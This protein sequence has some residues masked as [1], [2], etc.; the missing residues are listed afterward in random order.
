MKKFWAV[1]IVVSV[2][3]I[4]APVSAQSAE[5]RPAGFGAGLGFGSFVTGVS[6]KKHDGD[7]ALQGVIGCGWRWGYGRRGHRTR[8]S[9]CR[10]M[11]VSGDL[12]LSMPVI[13]DEGSVILAWNVGGGASVGV[14]DHYYEGDRLWLGGQFVA[15]LEFI[16]PGVPLD[17]VLEWRPSLLVIPTGDFWF[18]QAGFHVRYYF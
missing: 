16:F 13:T 4:A 8:G 1:V 5:G 10:G 17:L 14:W 2:L 18:G 9:Q 11:G 12:L 15:G 7:R 3:L 6:L